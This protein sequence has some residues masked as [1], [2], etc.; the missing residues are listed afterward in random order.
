MRTARPAA[1]LH[2]TFVD[3]SLQQTLETLA[4]QQHSTLESDSSLA[5]LVVAHRDR[6]VLAYIG[7]SD[8]HD[9]RR[10]GQVDLIQAVR[11]PGSA[12]TFVSL[13]GAEISQGNSF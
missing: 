2:P 10:A 3:R 9:P 8:F 13:R 5:I 12:R 1:T 6:R 11:S 7:A 4:R